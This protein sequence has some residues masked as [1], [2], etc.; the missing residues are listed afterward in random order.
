[1]AD[2]FLSYRRQDSQ[3][4]T[5]RLADRLEAWFGADRVFHDIESIPVGDDFAAAIRRALR[6]A[7]VLLVVV[8]PEWLDARD[9]EGR[10]RLDDPGDFVRLEI[11][12]ALAQGIA[13]VPVLVDGARMPAADRLPPSLAPFARCQAIELS[14]SRWQHDTGQLIEQLHSRFAIESNA[15]ARGDE[16]IAP[17]GISAPARF[18]LD[19]FELLTH[20]TRLIA[21]RQTGH[22]LDALRAFAFLAACSVLGTLALLIGFDGPPG[23]GRHAGIGALLA[24]VAVGVL[25]HGLLAGALAASLT[26]AWRVA[27][28][29]AEMR[30]V[31]LMAAFVYSGVWLGFCIGALLLASA[32]QLGDTGV[33][34]R[35]FERLYAPGPGGVVDVTASERWRDAEAMMTNAFAARG[36]LPLALFGV[37]IW[38]ATL[39]WAVV[40]WGAFRHAFDVGRARAA[41][42]TAVW[43]AMLAGLAALVVRLG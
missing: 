12:V 33:I 26:L 30:R 6:S 10:R 28:V 11:E 29:R 36:A 20:P 3:S 7:S 19:L 8:G 34:E 38:L 18:G 14:A 27:G 32:V 31:A 24:F 23:P 35:I 17:A 9:G 21:R 22:A 1:M 39:V 41:L 25:L 42:A 43:L 37:A 13:V 16:R 4:A 2:I 5:G 40:A 15:L